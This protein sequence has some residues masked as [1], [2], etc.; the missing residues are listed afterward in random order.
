MTNEQAPPQKLYAVYYSAKGWWMVDTDRQIIST[1]AEIEH[2]VM[3]TLQAVE[4]EKYEAVARL[5]KVADEVYRWAI[6]IISDGGRCPICEARFDV[7]V[8]V[9]E[10]GEGCPI[11]AYELAGQ[12]QKPK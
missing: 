7:F 2:Q 4:A 3:H 1:I 6:G 12:L 10:H 8:G 5:A 9:F 11:K